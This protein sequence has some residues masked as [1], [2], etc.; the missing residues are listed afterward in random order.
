MNGIR[1]SGKKRVVVLILSLLAVVMLA[2]RIGYRYMIPDMID[3]FV[4]ELLPALAVALFAIKFCTKPK[5]RWWG[6]MCFMLP[7]LRELDVLKT[8]QY[9]YRS[10][11]S[12]GH[13]HYFTNEWVT[14][15]YYPRRYSLRF[16]HELD[17]VVPAQLAQILVAATM[18]L[19][20]VIGFQSLKNRP[21]KALAWLAAVTVLASSA[22]CIASGGL[23]VLCSV[24]TWGAEVLW[25]V[26]LLLMLPK[27]LSAR[28]AE[29]KLN[30]L[31]AA[32]DAG[33]LSEADYAARRA[34]II[35]LL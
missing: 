12:E 18:V 13:Y 29:K 27:G 30:K 3:H 33:K 15:Y 20:L 11:N 5:M 7:L 32:R 17:F 34:K 2:L 35:D 9:F 16:P 22:F 8:N 23:P 24:M 26:C 21:T 19:L 31:I 14:E 10:V 6:T 1:L 28:A 25:I 4:T